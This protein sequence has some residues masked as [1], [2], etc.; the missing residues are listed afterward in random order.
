M[1]CQNCGSKNKQ[2]AKFC[3][4]CGTT[5]RTSQSQPVKVD[6]PVVSEVQPQAETKVKTNSE[7]QN[8]VGTRSEKPH[9]PKWWMWAVPLILV[10]AIGGG[11]FIYKNNQSTTQPVSSSVADKSSS[12]SSYSA[13]SKASKKSTIDFPKSTIQ[14]TIDDAFG[15][16]KGETSVY[17]SPTDSTEEVVSNSKAQR[18]ASN[19]KLFILI[20][21]YQQVNEGK[22]NLNDKYT[23]KDSDKVDGTGEIRNMSSGSEI[24]MQDLL[25]DMMEDSDNTAANI[26]IRQLGGMDKVNAQIKKIGAKDTK[27]ERMLMDTDA[28]KDGKDNYTSVADLGMVLKKIYNH[29]MVSTKYDNAMLDIL[30]KNNNHTK[31]PHDLPEEATVYNKTGEFDDYGVE[32]DAAIFGNNKGSFVIVVMSQDGSRDEQIKKMN[33]FGSVMYDGLLG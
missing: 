10:V 27:L 2:G 23:L 4:K 19:I 7:L 17:V 1:F 13:P 3:S 29:Q 30:K 22:L 25:E 15:D 20:T 21:A 32:N 5:L 31:L 16:M 14:G 26:V 33:S 9:G 12:S 28:L 11:F 6:K 24:S 18:A 8:E